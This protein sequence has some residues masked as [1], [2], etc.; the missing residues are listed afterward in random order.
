[1]T[2]HRVANEGDLTVVMTRVPVDIDRGKPFNWSLTLTVPG[3]GLSEIADAYS[4]EAPGA[5]YVSSIAKNF[6][7]G[8]PYFTE[9]VF[10]QSYY[11]KSRGGKV[12]GR[13]KIHISADYQPPPAR[14]E[15]EVF[16][17]P[18]GSRNLEYDPHKQSSAP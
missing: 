11:F 18:A 8:P 9:N 14:L 17:N 10:D 6:H 3:G 5:G 2:G 13:M 1:L 4:N 15:I 7:A 16:A 12:Y